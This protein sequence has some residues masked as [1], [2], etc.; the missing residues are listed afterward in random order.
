MMTRM[1]EMNEKSEGTR[2][3]KGM[4]EINGMK[5]LN[6]IYQQVKPSPTFLY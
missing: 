1:T 6:D 3:I 4:S 2:L 5:G